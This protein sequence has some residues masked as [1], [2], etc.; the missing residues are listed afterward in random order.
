MATLAWRLIGTLYIVFML[1]PLI[2]VVLFSFTVGGM[3]NFPIE[4]WS[5]R[6]WND[7]FANPAFCSA[8]INSLIIGLVV[9]VVSAVFGTMAA[10]GLSQL[11]AARA[12]MLMLILSVPLMLPPLVL[13]VALLSFYVAAGVRLGLATV[14]ASQI[15]FT[16]PF[17]ILVVMVRLRS[18]DLRIVESARDLGASRWTAFRT[19][20]LPVIQPSVI[21]AALI[22]LA[23]W[24]KFYTAAPP[25]QRR[26]VERYK[27]VKRA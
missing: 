4:T 23:L 5:L 15:L 17:V 25:R 9:S 1:S 2:L 3:A 19:V 13:G 18:F 11:S 14:I 12:N 8:L 24:A 10:M 7:L 20:T 22:S 27:I 26:S 21:G 16:L 6:W